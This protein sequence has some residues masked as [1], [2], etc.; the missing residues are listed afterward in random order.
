MPEVKDIYLNK[1]SMHPNNNYFA[2][3][4]SVIYKRDADGNRMLRGK[5]NPIIDT[6]EYLVEF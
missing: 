6:N 1:P 3:D 5:S 4:K 2:D